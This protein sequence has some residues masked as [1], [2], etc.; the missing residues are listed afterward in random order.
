CQALFRYV[1]PPDLG[2]YLGNLWASNS[3][4]KNRKEDIV[5]DQINHEEEFIYQYA[6]DLEKRGMRQDYYVFGHR[7]IAMDVKVSPTARYINLGDWI[8]YDSYAV[9]DGNE[10]SL[11]IRDPRYA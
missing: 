2:Q 9:F 1:L 6:S 7:H 10:L 11:K 4:K 8:R 3:F 5:V